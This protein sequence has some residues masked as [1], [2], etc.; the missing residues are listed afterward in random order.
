MGRHMVKPITELVGGTR[1]IASGNP[2][3][4]M[5]QASSKD[6]LCVLAESFNLMAVSLKDIP[7]ALQEAKKNLDKKK[8]TIKMI[9]ALA[10][11]GLD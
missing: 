8:R 10:N 7:D 1:L 5:I 9:S 11:L 4:A 6:E 3:D 2:T